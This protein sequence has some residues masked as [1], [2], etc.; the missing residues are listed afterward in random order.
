M[1]KEVRENNEVAKNKLRE[2]GGGLGNVVNSY[3]TGY[4]ESPS[5][6]RDVLNQERLGRRA[7][8]S[9]DPSRKGLREAAWEE[10]VPCVGRDEKGGDKERGE[11]T[12]ND[13]VARMGGGIRTQ[14]KVG[15]GKGAMGL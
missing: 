6:E 3:R 5:K 4:Q 13:V 8:G 2:R 15:C 1:E 11:L 9:A 7:E 14:R 10:H 12:G